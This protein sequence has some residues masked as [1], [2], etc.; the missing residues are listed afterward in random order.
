MALTSVLPAWTME[1]ACC[2]VAERTRV[3]RVSHGGILSMGS[4]GGGE[5]ANDAQ[6]AEG[7]KRRDKI[8]DHDSPVLFIRRV[9]T[10]LWASEGKTN[11]ACTLKLTSAE[12]GI[13]LKD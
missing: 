5:R 3:E 10:E 7:R 8:E 11:S 2:A 12:R 9:L 1:P 13:P 4:E 6:T